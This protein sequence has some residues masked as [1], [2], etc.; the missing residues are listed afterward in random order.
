MDDTSNTP[1]D[2]V[3]RTLLNDCPD[4]IIPVINHTFGTDFVIG[5]DTVQTGS[6]EFFFTDKQGDQSEVISD[7]HITIGGKHFHIECQSTPDGDII[8]RMF[9]YDVQIAMQHA[10]KQPDRYIVEFPQSAI[11]YLRSTGNTPDH[12]LIQLHVPGDSCSYQ[13]PCLKAKEYSAGEIFKKQLYFLIPFH[14]FAYESRFREYEENESKRQ[15]LARIYSA[16]RRQLDFLCET[17][18]I[19]EYYKQ[20]IIDMSNKVVRSIARNYSKTRE[21]ISDVMGGKILEYEAKTILNE[22]RREGRR[23][24]H[25]EGALEKAIQVYFNLIDRNYPPGE[26][27]AVAGLTDEQ[28]EKAVRE[29]NH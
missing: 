8:V 15:E 14:I 6:N 24:G 28:I 16:V 1:Y 17:G 3:F 19:S 5:R 27:Q 22:G 29:R 21:R 10:K 4:L 2:D 23:E 12:M 18:K 9:E 7:S 20:T 25:L 26:A 13:V 11:L